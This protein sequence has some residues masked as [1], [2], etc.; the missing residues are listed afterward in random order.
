VLE[1]AERDYVVGILINEHFTSCLH[2]K[3]II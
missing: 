1:T 3:Y 2:N